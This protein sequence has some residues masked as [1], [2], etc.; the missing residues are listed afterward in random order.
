M[1]PTYSGAWRLRS[2]ITFNKNKTY[3]KE[4]IKRLKQ[5]H[6]QINMQLLCNRW[7]R[8]AGKHVCPF[9]KFSV[10]RCQSC[11]KAGTVWW[12]SPW[13]GQYCFMQSPACSCAKLHCRCVSK[14]LGIGTNW[15]GETW[16]GKAMDSSRGRIAHIE[17]SQRWLNVSSFLKHFKCVI[18]LLGAFCKSG[19]AT[20]FFDM[21]VCLSYPSVGLELLGSRWTKS[22]EIYIRGIFENLLRKIKSYKI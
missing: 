14:S 21:S 9:L 15:N 10:I 13:S 11:L 17:Y 6:A 18:M 19:N 7:Q 16:A 5:L 8:T 20:I 1:L 22:Q 2:D 4:N 3:F 12:S